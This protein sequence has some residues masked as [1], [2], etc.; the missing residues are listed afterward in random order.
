MTEIL[1]YEILLV[2]LK[3]NINILFKIKSIQLLTYCYVLCFLQH[4]SVINIVTNMKY[5]QSP[6][7]W[8]R[9]DLIVLPAPLYRRCTSK[10]LWMAGLPSGQKAGIFYHHSHSFDGFMCVGIST[11]LLR[12]W[13]RIFIL[14]YRWRSQVWT[15]GL[16][17]AFSDGLQGIWPGQSQSSWTLWQIAHSG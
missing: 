11:N 9:Y 2:I 15:S 8:P 12:G 4:F 1:K 16:G 13:S 17:T 10:V 3:T 7:T 5:N 6:H 14:T